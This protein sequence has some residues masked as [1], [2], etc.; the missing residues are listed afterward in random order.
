MSISMRDDVLIRR[1]WTVH[2]LK[3]LVYLEE[4]LEN[5][6]QKPVMSTLLMLVHHNLILIE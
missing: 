2:V 1:L 5:E 3:L 6:I 4:R